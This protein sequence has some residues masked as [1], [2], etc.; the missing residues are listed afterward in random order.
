MVQVMCV[1]LLAFAATVAAAPPGYV[2]DAECA[3]CHA[4][5][6]H[7]YPSVGMSKSFYRP[8]PGDVIENFQKLPF[9]HD[10]SGDIMELRWRDGRLL[11]RRWQLDT[12]GKPINVFEQPVDWILGSGHHARTYLY[13][14][15]DGELYQLPLAWYSQT[16]EWAM[17]PGYD[18]RHHD[19]VLRPPRPACP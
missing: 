3:S 14:T 12:A 6:A 13:Q 10:K 15:P 1:A 2:D 4:A 16:K 8:R 9:R 17:A 18:R 19:G 7:T 11:F 5:I